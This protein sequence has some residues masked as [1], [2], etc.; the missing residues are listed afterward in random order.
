[1]NLQEVF[2]PYNELVAFAERAF[3]DISSANRD[4][5][6][7]ER[8]CDDCCHAVFGLFLVEAAYLHEKFQCLEECVR[9]SAI[10]RCATADEAA[11]E[12]EAKLRSCRH[13]PAQAERVMA[14]ERIR[15]PLL[16]ESRDCLLYQARPLT[17]RVYGIPT[18]IHGSLRA[19][20]KSGFSQNGRFGGFNLD[21]AQRRLLELS[22]A[23]IEDI[24]NVDLE[25]ASL[26]VSVSKAL[27]SPV[28]AIIEESYLK[29][30]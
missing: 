1:M 27:Q 20:G 5:V 23:M 28:H 8:G 29:E 15:C 11:L 26:L 12:L 17:C 16:S 3:A 19:C 24:E 6:R 30:K 21:L 14:M 18:L 10:E 13:D 2:E 22:V 25:K 7:C 9:N 4:L